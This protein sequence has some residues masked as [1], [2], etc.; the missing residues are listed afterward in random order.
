MM[1]KCP[2]ARETVTRERFDLASAS[3]S[4]F[5][6]SDESDGTYYV[7]VCDILRAEKL[8]ELVSSTSKFGL[9]VSIMQGD[10]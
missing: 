3:K 7:T 5:D 8:P 9:I 10:W 1:I 4:D 2:S 6:N